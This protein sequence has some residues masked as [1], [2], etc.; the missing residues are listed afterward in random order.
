MLSLQRHQAPTMHAGSTAG[1]GSPGFGRDESSDDKL[2]HFVQINKSFFAFCVRKRFCFMKQPFAPRWAW[3]RC[4]SE[5]LIK[6]GYCGEDMRQSVSSLIS[7]NIC[8]IPKQMTEEMG[9][10]RSGEIFMSTCVSA[11]GVKKERQT[12]GQAHPVH[13]LQSWTFSLCSVMHTHLPPV[14]TY[15]LY[16]HLLY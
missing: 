10:K 14:H 11:A 9:R 2:C 6:L 7:E 12:A 16:V 1:E 15:L 13:K 5:L 3:P 8:S 4:K